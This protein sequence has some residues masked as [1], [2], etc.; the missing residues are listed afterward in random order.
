MD[1]DLIW[2]AV[3]V[4]GVYAAGRVLFVTVRFFALLARNSGIK[5]RCIRELSSNRPDGTVY[6]VT[7][8]SSGR[9]PSRRGLRRLGVSRAEARRFSRFTF[10]YAYLVMTA[11]GVELW[12]R[13]DVRSSPTLALPWSQVAGAYHHWSPS[14]G[15]IASSGTHVLVLL[16]VDEIGISLELRSEEFVHEAI[17]IIGQRIVNAAE[18]SEP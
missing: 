3:T 15:Q 12:R 2:L 10:S 17:D 11:I 9:Y 14:G 4:T 8:Y 16:T 1:N 13:P 7:G 5:F 6:P 18:V